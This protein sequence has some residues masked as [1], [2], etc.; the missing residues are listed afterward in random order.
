MVFEM[1]QTGMTL[2]QAQGTKQEKRNEHIPPRL[3]LND[4]SELG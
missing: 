4:T 3:V 2:K 1:V